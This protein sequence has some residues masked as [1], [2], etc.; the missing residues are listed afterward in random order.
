M[1]LADARRSARY[2]ISASAIAHRHIDDDLELYA[3]ERLP[4]S[5]TAP[6]EEHLLVCEECRARLAA[7]EE[8]VGRCGRQCAGLLTALPLPA[9]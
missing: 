7:W 8:Y 5:N 1:G 4:E 2:W 6:V 3:I 9:G